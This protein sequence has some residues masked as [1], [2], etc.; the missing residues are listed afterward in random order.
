MQQPFSRSEFPP[1]GWEFYQPQTRWSAPTPKSSTF[2]QTVNLIIKHRFANPAVTASHKLATDPGAVGNELE[3][4]TRARLGMPAI[5]QDFP[6]TLPP[7]QA[8]A[9]SGAVQGLVAAVKQIAAGAALLLEWEESGRPPVDIPISEA[10]AALC[11]GCPKNSD[12]KDLARIFTEPAAKLIKRKFERLFSLNLKTTH[13]EALNVCT[14]CLCPLKLKVHTPVDLI[15][16]RLTGEQRSKLDPRCWILK[17][18]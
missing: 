15:L 2:D 17:G 18:E 8:P 5:G 7:A 14:A 12:E 11:D 13:D 9:V 3:N 16:K 6:K 1:G 4:Y 10:R